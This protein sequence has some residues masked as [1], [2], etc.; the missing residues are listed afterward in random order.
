[1]LSWLAA[2]FAEL[3]ALRLIKLNS[4]IIN[5]LDVVNLLSM[6]TTPIGIRSNPPPMNLFTVENKDNLFSIWMESSC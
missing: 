4:E 1:M 2:Q 6:V 3:E 5:K